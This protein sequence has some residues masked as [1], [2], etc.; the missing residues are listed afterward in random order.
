MLMRGLRHSNEHHEDPAA[1]DW[2]LDH[3]LT[4]DSI[5]RYG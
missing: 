4:D 2:K 5:F 1:I 3:G